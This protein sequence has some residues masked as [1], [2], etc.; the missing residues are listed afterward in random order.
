MQVIHYL[1]IA[2]QLALPPN[3]AVKVIELLVEPFGDLKDAIN[4]W[5]EYPCIV[6]CLNSHD[7]VEA[8]LHSLDGFIQHYIECADSTPELVE[9]LPNEYQ[10][11]LTII[12]DGN[13]NGLYLIKP[14]DMNLA[15]VNANG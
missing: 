5:Q 4:Y 6:V 2:D 10:L 15:E 3:V 14:T 12:N 11:S 13:G 1:P 7:K 9:F 8:V